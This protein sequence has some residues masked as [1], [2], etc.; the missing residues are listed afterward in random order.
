MSQDG[1]SWGNLDQQQKRSKH[2]FLDPI[3]FPG[4][5]VPGS[6]RRTICRP[7]PPL[8]LAARLARMSR[9]C[10]PMP[11]RF[12]TACWIT[13]ITLPKAQ[14]RARPELRFHVMK[15]KNTGMVKAIIFCCAGSIPG[16]GVRYCTRN[17]VT[18]KKIGK[19]CS[20]SG[21]ARLCSHNQGA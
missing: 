13:L 15:P 17:M 20:G 11:V 3:E 14:Y 12:M 4:P 18:I 21:A 8:R 1:Q 9:I 19:M 10:L 16:D 6:Y 7:L 2:F 5:T